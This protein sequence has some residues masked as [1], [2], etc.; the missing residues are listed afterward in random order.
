[1][2][3]LFRLRSSVWIQMFADDHNPPHFHIVGHDFEVMIRIDDLSI[4]VGTGRM[5]RVILAEALDW[6]RQNQERLRHE[7]I[8]LNERG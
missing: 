6:A 1:M 4:L 8:R 3:T 2:P 5:P 7:W